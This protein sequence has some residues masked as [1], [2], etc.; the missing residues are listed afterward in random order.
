MIQ[1]VHPSKI[2]VTMLSVAAFQRKYLRV[3]AVG[4]IVGERV[5]FFV[6]ALVGVLVGALVVGIA[7]GA[8]VGG[9]AGGISAANS[10]PCLQ[11]E[12]TIL[13]FVIT[14]GAAVP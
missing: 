12:Q 1:P 5:G 10:D 11:A 2:S 13:P 6:G 4:L 8:A 14:R 7:V 9:T 3:H